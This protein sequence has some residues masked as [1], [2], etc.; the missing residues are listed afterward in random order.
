MTLFRSFSRVSGGSALWSD[1]SPAG[2]LLRAEFFGAAPAGATGA[3]AAQ[4]T[5]SDTLAAFGQVRVAGSLAAHESG[6]DVLAASGR[7]RVSGALTTQE[8]GADALVATGRVRVAGSLGAQEAGADTIAA[9]GAVR[10]TGALSLQETGVDVFAAS[11]A[12]QT[13]TAAGVMAAR[14]SG[15]DVVAATGFVTGALRRAGARRGGGASKSSERPSAVASVR[16]DVQQFVR[17]SPA[18]ARRPGPPQFRRS[19]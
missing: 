5:G 13:A 15:A 7:V 18:T 4:E 11:G 9:S 17:P 12:V 1:P 6:A 19:A 16:D 10:V 8:G 14:E 3:L 2:N